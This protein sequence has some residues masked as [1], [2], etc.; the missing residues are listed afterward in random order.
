MPVLPA[1]RG[2]LGRAIEAS[3]AA[4]LWEDEAAACYSCGSC[5][6]VCPTCYCFDIRDENDL[7]PTSGRRTRCWDACMLP[8]FAV[9]AGGN[10]FRPAAG[11]RL[12][13]RVLRKAAWIERRSGLPGC[14]G[15][16]RC[17]RACTA[18]I[19]LREILTR[20]YEEASDAA[21]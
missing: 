18:R 19:S 17:D 2:R 10:N 14:V 8:G 20:A 1:E 4:E 13:H 9:V 21:P 3:Y 12:R 15:C 11:Q 16:A 7:P 5:N 6:L